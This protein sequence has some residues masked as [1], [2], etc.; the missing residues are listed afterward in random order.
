MAYARGG[1]QGSKLPPLTME[2]IKNRTFGP[3][4][5]FSD[6]D[7]VFLSSIKLPI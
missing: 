6:K 3:I 2:K 4:S 7:C 5:V 1:F